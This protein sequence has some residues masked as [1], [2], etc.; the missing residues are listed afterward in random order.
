MKIIY[1]ALFATLIA[2]TSHASE[3]LHVINDNG[4][5]EIYIPASENPN[6]TT[7][8]A[9]GII[10]DYAPRTLAPAANSKPTLELYQPMATTYEAKVP[11]IVTQGAYI[12]LDDTGGNYDNNSD[13]YRP[14]VEFPQ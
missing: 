9:T 13:V 3:E 4:D 14:K 5:A 8:V 12:P 1:T 7:Y 11:V 2:I 10:S 6:S